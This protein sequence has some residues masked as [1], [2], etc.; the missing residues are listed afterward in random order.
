MAWFSWLGENEEHS[1]QK[2][3]RLVWDV[4]LHR[5]FLV[6]VNDLGI[7]SEFVI[8]N[9]YFFLILLDLRT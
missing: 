7:D 9:I 6:V 2:K 3:P 4:E 5:K 8:K 1:N